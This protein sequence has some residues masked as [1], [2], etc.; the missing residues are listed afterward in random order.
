[1]STTVTMVDPFFSSDAENAECWEQVSVSKS[2]FAHVARCHKLL[3]DRAFNARD[4][5]AER[6]HR[7]QS[8]RIRTERG[9]S[10]NEMMEVRS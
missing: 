10:W 3:A 8:K 2:D 6:Y 7:A 9:L 1:M 5:V 4:T